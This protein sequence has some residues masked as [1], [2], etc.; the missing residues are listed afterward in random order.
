MLLLLLPAALAFDSEP[1]PILLED[2]A[3]VFTN[4]E[5]STGY[6]PS[7][8][9]LAVQFAIEANGGAAASMQGTGDLSW[10]DPFRLDLTPTAEGGLL[11]L[12]ASL[13]AVV[14]MRIDLSDWGYKGDFEL[15]RRGFPMEAETVFTPFVLLGAEE[16]RVEAVDL[17]DKNELLYYSLE[18]L[19]GLSLDFAATVRT[20]T[21]VG[22]EGEQWL[23]G[24]E[25]VTQE[26]QAVSLSPASV[27]SYLVDT[28]YSAS[29]DATL[30][31]VFTPS[32]EACADPFGCVDLLSFDIPINLL[33]DSFSQD[34]PH[35]QQVY[36]LPLLELDSEEVDFG[37]VEVGQLG[38]VDLPLHNAGDLAVEGT[39]RIEGS[40]AFTVYPD[41]FTALP[42]GDDGLVVSFS[43]TSTGP[44]EAFLILESNDPSQPQVT[45]VLSAN[46]A[47]EDVPDVADEVITKPLPGC[48]CQVGTPA[49]SPLWGL[50]L[51]LLLFRRRT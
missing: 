2:L 35:A 24:D 8:S 39:A 16:P 29:W 10:P 27:A 30:D 15:G 14:S 31:L 18:I 46:G 13:D 12:D 3:E 42:G 20:E 22:F 28:V 9:P 32:V 34:F 26:G 21:T 43:P 23:V 45:I 4:A 44:I 38:T 49:A 41:T 17:G 11:L 51:G 37:D 50:L 36:P 33:T 25:V 1:Q 6:V 7:G 47:E 48:G 19:P 40:D 5:F